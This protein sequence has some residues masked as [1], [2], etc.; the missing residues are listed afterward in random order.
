MFQTLVFIVLFVILGRMWLRLQGLEQ[1]LDQLGFRPAGP[2]PERFQAPA[3][4]AASARTEQW[5]DL[6]PVREPASVPI[7]EAEPEAEAERKA[8]PVPDLAIA[9]AAQPDLQAPADPEPAPAGF[10]PEPARGF[11]FEELFGRRLPIWAGGVTLAVAG[12]LIVR[13]SIEA[14]LLSPLVRF[15]AGLAFGGALIAGAELALRFEQRVRDPRVRQALAGAG[16]ASLYASILVGVNLY[17]LIGP[18]TAF[19]AMAAITAMAMVLSLRFGA[20]SALLGLVGGLAA[21]ALVGAGEPNVPLLTLYLALAVAGLSVLSRAKRWMWLGVGALTGGLGWG[22]VLAVGG[23]LGTADT[24]SVGFYLLVVGIALPMLALPSTAARLMRIGGSLAA[25]AQMAALVA[26]GGFA[27]LHWGLF[28]LISIAIVWLSRREEAYRRLPAVGL[29]LALLL[30]AAWP[31]PG[32]LRFA[33]VLTGAASIFGGAALNDLWRSKGGLVEA[34]Q[35]A[36]VSLAG[37]FLAW[38]HF[39]RADGSADLPLAAASLA[40]GAF[41]AAAAALGWRKA[42]RKDDERFSLLVCAAALLGAAAACL[43]I[44]IETLPLA[45]A[46]IACGLLILALEAEDARIEP[47]AWAAGVAAVALLAG[48]AGF[49]AEAKRLIGLG[50]PVD[51]AMALVRWVGLGSAA[52][53]FAGHARLRE[54]REGAQACAAMF[55]YG[56][57]AQAVLADYLSLVAPAA[58]LGLALAARRFESKSLRPALAVM[59][60]ITLCWAAAPLMLWTGA[61]LASLAGDPLLAAELPSVR[62]SIQRLLVPAL[63]IAGSARAA[64]GQ[65]GTRA[66][67]AASAAAG[68][69]SFVSAHILFKQAIGLEAAGFESYGLAERSAWELLLLAGAAAAWTL[70]SRRAAYGLGGAALAH[71]GWYGLVLHNPLWAEQAVGSLPMLNLLACLYGLPLAILAAAGRIEP[72]LFPR[73]ERPRA[74]L[75][76]ALLVLLAFSTLRQL[77]HGSILAVPGLSQA[78]DIARSVVAVGLAVGFLLRGIRIGSIDWR[79]GSLVLMLAA[80]AKVFLLDASGLEGLM[81]IASFV[82][83]GF[84]LIGIGWLYSRSPAGGQRASTSSA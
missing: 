83:L 23:V 79:I 6:P 3:A 73:F 16:I 54:A 35:I 17:A 5:W 27:M 13:Y 32:A 18:M 40:A 71:L 21:P 36:A 47:A 2:A 66:R 78:E 68:A 28:G 26:T 59:I 52:L 39:H 34:G 48:A 14:G 76:M 20:P 33:L 29:A 56:A 4:E 10:T 7:R 8:E 74:V 57:A 37:A 12:V 84:S 1:R 15:V 64:A 49:E 80:V 42:G 9:E 60:A 77:V 50:A 44:P 38:V 72:R 69:L 41:P 53:V 81:R 19:A 62:D 51:L 11:G 45:I 46:A 63:L 82:A 75:Q 24:L 55:A 58:L 31:D 25:A 67:L 43:A 65:A 61:A 30:A 22:L 70:R